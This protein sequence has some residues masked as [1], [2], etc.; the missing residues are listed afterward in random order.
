M[1]WLRMGGVRMKLVSISGY[2]GSGKTTFARVLRDHYGFEIK[3]FAAILKD[4]AAAFLDKHEVAYDHRHLYGTMKDKDEIL[5][6]RV[7]R[8]KPWS[9]E[10]MWFWAFFRSD[11]VLITSRQF[12]QFWGTEFRRAHFGEDYWGER[13]VEQFDLRGRYVVD[14]TRFRNEYAKMQRLGAKM[15]RIDRWDTPA[16][17]HTS[18]TD[19]DGVADWDTLVW[20]RGTLEEFLARAVNYGASI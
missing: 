12:L 11:N 1:P 5:R 13:L 7:S 8:D 18:E 2:A 4:E 19:L 9:I 14:D 6:V 17:Q 10:E 3:S 16:S 20:N 15:V